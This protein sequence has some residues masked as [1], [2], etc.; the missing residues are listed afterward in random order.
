[1]ILEAII[2]SVIIGFIRG[3]NLR[4]LRRVNKLTALLFILGALIQ[5]LLVSLD[6]LADNNSIALII[7]YSKPIQILSYILILIGLFT[8]IK[9]KSLWV[10]FT[11]YI[12][13]FL[14]L[15]SNNW[16]IPNLIGEEAVAGRFPILG[17]I[18]QFHTPYP[19]PKAISVGDLIIAFGIFSFIQEIM[20]EGDGSK[21]TFKF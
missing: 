13:N 20:L 19:L 14:F 18:I 5:Y 1:M 7:R 8:N 11:G 16:T 15:L 10:V 12:L 2:I 3:G 17:K 9:F 21:Y 4:G 6:Q